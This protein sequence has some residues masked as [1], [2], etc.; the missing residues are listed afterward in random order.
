MGNI[1]SITDN[2]KGRVWRSALFQSLEMPGAARAAVFAAAVIGLAGAMPQSALAQSLKDGDGCDP[3]KNYS[4]LDSYLGTGVL[5]RFFN[6]YILEDGHGTAPADPN[7]PSSRRDGW[8]RAAATIPPLAY[9]EWPAGALT[10]IGVTRPLSGGDSPLMVAT[11][12]TDVGKW[13]ADNHLQVY[14]WVEAGANLSTNSGRFSNNPIAYTY[15]GNSADLNQA[16]VYLERLPDTVQ[17]DHLDW[18]IR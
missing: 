15:S 12:N 9:S 16:V 3:Y 2:R 7:A 17:T 4:C 1:G 8:P 5:E 11:A 13:M 6:Y 14:G 18:G 10:Y